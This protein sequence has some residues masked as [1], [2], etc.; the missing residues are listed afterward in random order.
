LKS[1]NRGVD[2][3]ELASLRCLHVTELPR[4]RTSEYDPY[5]QGYV[6]L[7]DADPIE[8][9]RSQI[10]SFQRLGV[11]SD[12]A[13]SP[14][15]APGE[16]STK[17]VLVHLCDF[18]RMFV[19]RALRFSRG[20]PTPIEGFEQD[21]YIASAEANARP[22]AEILRELVELRRSTVGLFESLSR[23]QL[24]RSGVAGGAPI[25]VRAVVFIVPGHCK[26]H[27]NDLRRLH[28]GIF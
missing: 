18:E 27:L 20:D 13:A 5:Y 17:E 26:G 22:L 14:I 2:S 23:A 3:T 24:S 4:P 11:L 6:E 8:H 28:P 15:P 12:G 16:W 25:T 9:L 10:E 7:A 19:Y 21:A 1:S